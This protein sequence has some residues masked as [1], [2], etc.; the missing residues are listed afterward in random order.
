MTKFNC[1]ACGH[2]IELHT[3]PNEGDGCL[4]MDS[5]GPCYCMLHNQEPT[6]QPAAAHSPLPW[7]SEHRVE[8]GEDWFDV[9]SLDGIVVAET[10]DKTGTNA[11]LIVR[12]VNEGPEV[13]RKLALANEL[14]Y[15]LLAYWESLEKGSP[16]N[17]A[18][19]Q[20]VEAARQYQSMQE[21]GK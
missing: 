13:D 1:S 14:A 19:L 9:Y 16:N 6:K 4:Y 3:T 12:R 21:K 7:E 2:T 8:E 17:M 10:F 18:R 20:A 5:G 15:Y 11:Q